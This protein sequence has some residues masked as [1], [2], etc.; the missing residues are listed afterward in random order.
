MFLFLF[1][2]GKIGCALTPTVAPRLT[3]VDETQGEGEES[4]LGQVHLIAFLQR[5]CGFLEASFAVGANLRAGLPVF[6]ERGRLFIF[7]VC[8]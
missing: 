8:V 5:S 2:Y 1:F 4:I 6:G 7:G 3:C